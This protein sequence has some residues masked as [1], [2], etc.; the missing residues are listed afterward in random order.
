MTNA[1]EELVRAAKEARSVALRIMSAEMDRLPQYR[2]DGNVDRVWEILN[3]LNP[4]LAAIEQQ[5][6]DYNLC[7]ICKGPADNGHDREYPPNPYVCT[8]CT[9]EKQ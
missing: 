8:R 5:E 9:A 3:A 7:P 6:N 1:I 4:A 2:C